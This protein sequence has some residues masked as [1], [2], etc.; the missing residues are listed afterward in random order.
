MRRIAFW[1]STALVA[2]FLAA[3]GFELL[4]RFVVD[5]GMQYDLEM[6][7]YALRLK[8]ISGDPLIGHVHVAGGQSRLMGVDFKVNSK[9]LRDRE[10]SYDR[11]PEKRRILML[12]DSFTV[13]WG[14]A[15]D[16]TFSKKIERMYAAAGVNTEVIDAGVGNYNTVQEVQYFLTEGYKYRPD[17][18]VLNYFVNDAEPVTADAPPGVL[19]RGCYACVVIAGR[20]DT[21]M[22]RFF[23]R[24]DWSE[25]YLGL[26]DGGARKGWRDA[27]EAMH[28]LA[29][30]CR[31]SGIVLLVVSIPDLHDVQ[32][33]RLQSI[34]DLVG[35]AARQDGASFVD[36]LPYL[37]EQQSSKLWVTEAD[38]HPNALA[39]SVIAKGIFDAMQKLGVGP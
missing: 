13:G 21:V 23:G 2:M 28:K 11:V 24:P 25:Y 38:P 20:L 4:S 33:Y 37:K 17:V 29:D 14:V 16:D 35:Q 6:W 30:F 5:D 15:L 31:K 19:M 39:H 1:L 26:Y 7:K 18:V 34:T 3:A 36:L 9:G 32:S 22:R 10:F 27:R 8:K 12:G